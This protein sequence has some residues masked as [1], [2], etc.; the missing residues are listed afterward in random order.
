MTNKGR[1]YLRTMIVGLFVLCGLLPVNIVTAETASQTVIITITGNI[2]NTN[3]P[4]FNA[5]SDPFLNYHERKFEQAYEFDRD[6]LMALPQHQVMARYKDWPR[7]RGLSGP[8]LDDI[9]NIIG[10][11]GDRIEEVALDGYSIEFDRTDLESNNWILAITES[12]KP[13]AMGGRGPA[14]IVHPVEAPES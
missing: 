5:F 13:L 3:R 10:A 6:M 8:R 11:E 1:T 14:W 4:T 2:A 9:L 12:G 7:S